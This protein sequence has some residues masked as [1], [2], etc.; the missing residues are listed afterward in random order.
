MAAMA[1]QPDRKTPTHELLQAIG[2][3]AAIAIECEVSESAVSQWA[4]E[5][6]LPKPSG[7]VPAPGSPRQALG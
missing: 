6:Q 1:T 3:Q 2:G 5:N 4:T 7:E